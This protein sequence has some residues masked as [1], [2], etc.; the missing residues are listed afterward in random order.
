MSNDVLIKRRKGERTIAMDWHVAARRME[1]AACDWGNGLA[2][3]RIVCDD[4][5]HLTEPSGQSPCSSCGKPFCRAC[6]P[7]ACPRCA[8]PQAGYRS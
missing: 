7:A 6:H 5:L 2:V 4:Q 3:E 1:P 8:K